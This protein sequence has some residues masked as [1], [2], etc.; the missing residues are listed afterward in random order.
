MSTPEQQLA[1]MLANLPEK[2]GKPL[3][4]WLKV[5]ANTG[6]DKH[7][8]IV[9]HLKAEHG[10]THGFANLIASKALEGD[11][12]DADLVA[13]QYAGPKAHLRPLHDTIVAFAELL[14]ADVEI[15]PKKA[16][17][18]LRRKKQFALITPA[19]RTRIDL[20]LALK[21]KPAAGRLETYNTMCSHRVRL[22]TAEDFDQ[23]VKAWMQEAYANAG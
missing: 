5:V 3:D 1:T 2:T 19:T 17:V 13:Q 18:S 21:G 14:G 12:A 15:A 11:A 10:V 9:K 20:G 8:Q 16:S 6:L 7:G 4:E 22:E 23:A